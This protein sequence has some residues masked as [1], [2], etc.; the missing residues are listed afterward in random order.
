M[1]F[2]N[3]INTNPEF[4]QSVLKLRGKKLGCWCAPKACHGDV[5]VAYIEWHEQVYPEYSHNPTQY[6][7]DAC[8]KCDG[9]GYLPQ[10]AGI[11]EGKCFRCHGSGKEPAYA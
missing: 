5:I 6:Q 9:S 1:W 10:Y 4:K 2:W 11:F 3:E 7:G 8:S